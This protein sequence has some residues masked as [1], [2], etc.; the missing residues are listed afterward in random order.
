M[1]LTKEQKA[2]LISK[3]GTTPHDTGRAEAQI[4]LMTARIKELT[5]HLETHVKDHH[6][7]RGLMKLVGKR[8]RLLEYLRRKDIER[9][10][11]VIDELGIRR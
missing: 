3:Y 4:A 5:E 9:Y 8:R 6:S 1:P 2:E 10:R 11:K 7:R